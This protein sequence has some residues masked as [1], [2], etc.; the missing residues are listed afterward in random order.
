[1]AA[2]VVSAQAPSTSVNAGVYSDAQATRGEKT[3]G[4]QCGMCHE[5]NRFAGD[6]FTAAWSG[7][8]LQ[9]LFEV[10]S[11]SMPETNPG[12]LPAQEYADVIAYLLRLNK[13]PA[14]ASELKGTTEAMSAVLMEPPRPGGPR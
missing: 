13:Y 10:V 3:F 5:L 8:P 4:D 9:V 12:G 11:T 7:R 2:G 14:G 1:M 6:D